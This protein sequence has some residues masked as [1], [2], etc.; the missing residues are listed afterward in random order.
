MVSRVNS[1]NS[2]S[3]MRSIEHAPIL[4]QNGPIRLSRYLRDVLFNLFI[5]MPFCIKMSIREVIL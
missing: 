4:V 1:V 5:F 3:G 2:Y